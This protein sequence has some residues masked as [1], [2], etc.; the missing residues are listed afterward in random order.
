MYTKLGRKPL[1][2]CRCNIV[3]KKITIV[4]YTPA[5]V[6]AESAGEDGGGEAAVATA[7]AAAAAASVSDLNE[8]NQ[9]Y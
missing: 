9:H 4:W 5:A 3:E 7:A 2:I 1:P 6:A 8:Q